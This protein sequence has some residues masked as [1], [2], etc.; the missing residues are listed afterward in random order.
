MKRAFEADRRL[1]DSRRTHDL[2]R[3]RSKL[4]QLELV[5]RGIIFTAGEIHRF[6]KFVGDQVDH[7]FLGLTNVSQ[8]VFGFAVASPGLLGLT[9]S[10]SKCQQWRVDANRIKKGKWRKIEL[11][12][13]ARCGYPGDGTRRYGIEHDAVKLAVGEFR[14]QIG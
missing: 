9:K 14:R 3:L 13:C 11:S 2:R 6:G 7:K 10:G 1:R 4:C 5:H 12:R 8:R